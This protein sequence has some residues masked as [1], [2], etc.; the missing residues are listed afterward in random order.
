MQVPTSEIAEPSTV[1]LGVGLL[2]GGGVDVGPE[3][4]HA[5]RSEQAV[6]TAAVMMERTRSL[7]DRTGRSEQ[8]TLARRA[9]LSGPDRQL[10]P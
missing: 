1:D 4:P 9:H 2:D 6:R 10:R 8:A 7:V 5:T 3:L